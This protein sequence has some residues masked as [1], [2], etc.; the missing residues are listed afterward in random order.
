MKRT[1][2]RA[3]VGR[4]VEAPVRYPAHRAGQCDCLFQFVE[5][6]LIPPAEQSVQEHEKRKTRQDADQE[7]QH[8]GD[9]V[10]LPDEA[11]DQG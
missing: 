1:E 7:D 4:L 10:A 5:R 9:L 2:A 3:E 6:I 8:A 11:V